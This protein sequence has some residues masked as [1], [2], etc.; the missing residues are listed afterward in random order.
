M[1]MSIIWFAIF[2]ISLVV[3]FSLPALV[4]VWFAAGSLAALILSLFVGNSLI[5]LQV[6]L[7]V[8]VSVLTLAILRPIM[9]KNKGNYRTNIDSLV[10]KI[11]KC[12]EKIEKYNA[13]EVKIEGLIWTAVFDN[14][15]KDI[16][17]VGDLVTVTKVDGNKL[18]VKKFEEE[19][20]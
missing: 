8:V 18:L 11:A 1:I 5:W 14:N 17:N 3:E 13:G 6:L 10:G 19:N 20:K 4:S 9:F 16:I 12:T 15:Q 7:F 2:I